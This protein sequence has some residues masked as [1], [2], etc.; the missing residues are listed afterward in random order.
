MDTST[1]EQLDYSV[2]F[3]GTQKVVK[4]QQFQQLAKQV[5]IPDKSNIRKSKSY[6]YTMKKHGLPNSLTN[7]ILQF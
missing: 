4:Q 5:F 7:Q 3:M 6:R 1:R 2:L